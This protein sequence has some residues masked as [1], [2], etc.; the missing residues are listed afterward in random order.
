MLPISLE[1]III[2][3]YPDKVWIGKCWNDMADTIYIIGGVNQMILTFKRGFDSMPTG[4]NIKHDKQT[5]KQP[6]N[7]HP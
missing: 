1:D 3:D 7:L 5:T 4:R 2:M 6:F